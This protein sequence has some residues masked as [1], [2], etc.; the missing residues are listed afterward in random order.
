[1]TTKVE[2]S[3]LAN[4][5]AVSASISGNTITVTYSDGSVT[6]LAL[7]VPEPVPVPVPEAVPTYAPKVASAFVTGG[8]TTL[9]ASV[10]FTAPS[11]GVLMAV[12]SLNFSEQA[13]APNSPNQLGILAINGA[14]VAVDSTNATQAHSGSAIIA[15]GQPCSAQYTGGCSIAFTVWVTLLFVPN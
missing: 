4:K 10:W 8:G 6:N 13:G 3:M 5:V 1:M 9:S 12:G 2:L 14:H 15:A 7:P 11:A